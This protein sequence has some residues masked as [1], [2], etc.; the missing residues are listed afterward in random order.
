MVTH[1]QVPEPEKA[2]MENITIMD[3][4]MNSKY[5]KTADLEKQ[6]HFLRPILNVP[7][8][9]NNRG[10]VYGSRDHYSEK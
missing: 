6:F 3:M 5:G 1:R 2:D 4:Q 9:R 10:E 8:G 7:R